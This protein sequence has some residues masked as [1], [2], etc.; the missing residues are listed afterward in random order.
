[1]FAATLCAALWILP[2]SDDW[3]FLKYFDNAR[4]LGQ[5][6]YR[7]LN[8]CLLL[9]RKYWRPIED[10]IFNFEKRWPWLFPYL[11]HSLVV[12]GAFAS[13]WLAAKVAV[14]M[15]AS[16]R[17]SM[18]VVCAGILAA[19]NMGAIFSIDS[20]TQ[21]LASTFGLLSIIA[22]LSDS[23]HG[24]LW[25]VVS[26]LLACVSKETGFI[27]LPAGPCLKTINDLR[28][29]IIRT[30]SVQNALRGNLSGFM[31][32]LVLC[33]VYLGFYAAMSE[34]Y[35][36]QYPIEEPSIVEYVGNPN[37]EIEN[38][39]FVHSQKSHTLTPQTLIKNIAILYVLGIA[40]VNVSGLYYNAIAPLLLSLMLCW[41]LPVLL[42]RF[43]KKAGSNRRKTVSMVALTGVMVSVPSLV[44]RA[45]EISPFT[46][47]MIFLIAIAILATG[48]K[49]VLSD[50]ILLAIFLAGTLIT[51]SYKY[52]LA[53]E[54]GI[55]GA[56]MAQEAVRLSPANPE[57]VLWVG[58]DE[59]HLENA[60]AAFCRSPYRAFNQ[61]DA[62]IR[63]YGYI[64]PKK[65]K[66]I[67]VADGER[68]DEIVDSIARAN[69][70]AYDCVWVTRGTNVKVIRE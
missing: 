44:T 11:Q 17:A 14:K 21:V 52:S 12:T 24:K 1:M 39:D 46:S 69:A 45:G 19:T 2:S 13:G 9:Y 68:A 62:A 57:K 41:A 55:S 49:L 48:Y 16:R 25:W 4:D 47:N 29:S 59:D 56:K 64:Y 58:V 40:P 38:T 53:L 34:I 67:I 27:F 26:G 7:W 36:L 28:Y 61:G 15:G 43:W 33:L 70:A 20:L 23:R 51:D 6:P 42:V 54:G 8:D 31:V 18:A 5:D 60:G 22:Y 65:L 63:S 50:K 3:F 37:F 66:K 35:K 10:V 30:S 32:A